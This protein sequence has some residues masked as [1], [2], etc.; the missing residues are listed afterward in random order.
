MKGIVFLNDFTQFKR[1]VENLFKN[2]ETVCVWLATL[3]K[4]NELIEYIGIL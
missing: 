2:S 3:E 1:F 4:Y